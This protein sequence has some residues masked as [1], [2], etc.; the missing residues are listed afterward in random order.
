[1]DNNGIDISADEKW[2]TIREVMWWKAH[3]EDLCKEL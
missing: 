3:F 1:M 2:R